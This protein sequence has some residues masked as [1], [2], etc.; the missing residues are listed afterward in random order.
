MITSSNDKNTQP[1]MPVITSNTTITPF[2]DPAKFGLV[3]ILMGGSSAERAVSLRSGAAVYDAL[4]RCGVDALAID[5]ADSL[6]ANVAELA[7]TVTVDRVFNC[8]HG[9]GG[10]DGVLQGILGAM[11]L[12]YTGSGVMASA[13]TM[14]KLRTKLCWRG[15]GLAT[16]EW[17]LLQ[18]ESDIDP[19][20]AKLGFPVI[21]KPAQEGSSVGISKANT[22][23]ELCQAMALALACRCDVYAEQWVDGKEYTVAIL[24]N[25]ALPIIHVESPN[26]FYDYDAKYHAETTQYHC[27]SGLSEE[28][29]LAIRELAVTANKVV[30]AKGWARVDIFIDNAGQYQLIEINTVPGMTDHSLMPMAAKAAG[31]GFDELVWRILE[32]SFQ[33]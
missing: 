6:I 13:L 8:I 25:E 24:N 31:I 16:P 10:E 11:A 9:R 17:H 28:Q 33:Q 2:G 7:L 18:D 26:D 12:P 20:I 15:Y 4:I 22:R 29:E 5:V 19:C 21:V 1:L 23:D 27:P 30:G 3:A 32:T 14:D